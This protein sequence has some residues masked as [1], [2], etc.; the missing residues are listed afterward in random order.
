MSHDDCP[1]MAN[2]T[3]TIS[4]SHRI[5]R[6]TWE[7]GTV[8]RWESTEELYQREARYTTTFQELSS[9]RARNCDSRVKYTRHQYASS[10]HNQ[11][12][13]FDYVCHDCRM[14]SL[15]NRPG[16]YRGHG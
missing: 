6:C 5:L 13:G 10:L 8:R 15:P 1:H 4:A 9:W 7:T 16:G 2:D 3:V 14:S 12:A 11:M